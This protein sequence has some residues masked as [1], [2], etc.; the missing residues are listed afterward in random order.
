MRLRVVNTFIIFLALYFFLSINISFIPNT[1]S[2]FTDS[3]K[4]LLSLPDSG[5]ETILAELEELEEDLILSFAGKLFL[6]L[7]LY[8]RINHLYPFSFTINSFLIQPH[9]LNLPPPLS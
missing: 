4:S 1:K 5:E 6:N 9:L 7:Y 3:E 8:S 2:N